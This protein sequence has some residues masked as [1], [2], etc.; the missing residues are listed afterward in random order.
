MYGLRRFFIAWL[1]ATS[2]VLGSLNLM[3]E[4]VNVDNARLQALMRDGVPVV[5]VRTPGEWEQTGVI[6]GSHRLMFFDEA[7]RYDAQA[8][9]DQLADIAGP[10]KPVALVC[11]VGGR[12][13][14]ISQF[15]SGQVGYTKVYNVAGGIKAWM[16][17]GN[18]TVVPT[19]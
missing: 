13:V 11:A 18:P 12:T 8:W 17:D 9:L 4:V 19:P 6:E 2:L 10:D 15:L 7:G 5:D 3:A 14:A 1:V 16:D